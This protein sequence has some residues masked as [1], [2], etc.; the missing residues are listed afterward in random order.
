MITTHSPYILT[1]INNLMQA[2]QLA[3]KDIVDPRKLGQI[4]P[5]RYHVDPDDVAAYHFENG[6]ATSIIDEEEGLIMA[7]KIDDVSID[8]SNQFNKLLDLEFGE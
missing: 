3:K 5:K 7:D 2:G 6:T 1:S 8:L 4:V